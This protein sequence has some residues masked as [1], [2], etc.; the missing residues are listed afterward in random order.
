MSKTKDFLSRNLVTIVFALLCVGALAASGVTLEFF[1][2]ELVTRVCRNAVLI[3]SLIIPVIAGLGLNFSIVLG[4]MSAQTGLILI[5]HFH[6]TGIAGILVCLIISIPIS[7]ILGILMGKL[8]NKT[9]GQEMITGMIAGFFANGV[10]QFIFIALVG[11]LI[12]MKDDNLMLSTGIGLK[13]TM[14]L[15]DGSL[16]ALDNLFLIKCDLFVLFACVLFIAYQVLSIVLN[17]IKCNKGKAIAYTS[18]IIKEKMIYTIVSLIILAVVM[19]QPQIHYATQTFAVPALT[20]LISVFVAFFCNFIIKTKLGQDFR[21]IGQDMKV[22]VSSGIDVDRTRIIAISMSTVLACLGQYISLQNIG[23][24]STYS[25]HENVATFAIAALL[26]GGAS[27]KE[28]KIKHAFIGAAMFHTLFTVAPAVGSNL[29][30][31]AVYGEYFRIFVSYGV[32]ALSLVF[33]AVQTQKAR[34]NKLK[35]EASL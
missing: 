11:G 30:G 12:P 26:V 17:K 9:K 35:L 23:S 22:A 33:N 4:A 21:A 25:A 5:T 16:K 31:D 28:A 10:Y 14:V 18:Q 29:F 24:F 3:L 13:S 27:A 34:L 7:I 20:L 8:F 1:L 6:L 15:E 19:L 32:I 2:Q